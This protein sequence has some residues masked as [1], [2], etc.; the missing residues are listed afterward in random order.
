M[1]RRRWIVAPVLVALA[2]TGC[3]SSSGDSTS[4]TAQTRTVDDQQVEQGIEQSLSTSSTKVTKVS[5]PSDEPVEKGATFTCS[6]TFSNSATGK[7]TVTQQ[8]ANRYTYKLKSG[9]VQIPG[10][11]VEAQLK[12]EL[13]SGGA[14]NATVN[15]PD[16]IIVKTGTTVTC[17]VSGAQGAA[18]GTVTFTFSD[19]EGTVDPSS[20]KTS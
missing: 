19:A 4:T 18:N 3:G 12:K 8:G 20:V 14:P 9:S 6:V 2:A 1:G 16:N 13:A 15:C 5:C 17:D 10:S 11:S 7:V